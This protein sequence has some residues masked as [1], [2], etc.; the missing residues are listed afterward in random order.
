METGG[1]LN[2]RSSG[3]VGRV[4]V[5][6][7]PGGK[8][9]EEDSGFMEVRLLNS[10][11]MPD[12]WVSRQLT[13]FWNDFNRIHNGAVERESVPTADVVEDREGYHF[14]FEMPGLKA[15]TLE[16]K[17]ED[18]SLTIEAERVRPTWPEGSHVHLAER[19]YGK[20]GRVF[21]M[22]EDANPEGIDA[23]YRDGILVV[24]VPKKPESKPRKITVKAE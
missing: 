13:S 3:P 16:V 12:G 11:Y 17:V 22:P 15:D 20:I 23:T 10:E 4:K 2:A 1:G 6:I 8:T 24:N 14:C 5:K 21:R 7:Q 9:P 18:G 19:A